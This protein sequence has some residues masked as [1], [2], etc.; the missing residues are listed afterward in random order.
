ML[1]YTDGKRDIVRMKMNKIDAMF[2][3]TG[4]LFAALWLAWTHNYKTDI[5]V[6]ILFFNYQWLI[7]GLPVEPQSGHF[8]QIICVKM[9]KK[10]LASV[11]PLGTP[12]INWIRISLF[13]I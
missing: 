8:W 2:I 9:K 6:T 13:K 4:D 12:A 3:G 5:L 7:P 10:N 1:V 11:V